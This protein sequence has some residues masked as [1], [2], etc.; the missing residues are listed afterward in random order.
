MLSGRTGPKPVPVRA[1]VKRHE[2]GQQL[3]F[4]LGS[5]REARDQ[6]SGQWL[7]GG[8]AAGIATRISPGS[9]L[10][11]LIEPSPIYDA[12]PNR[13]LSQHC[14]TQQPDHRAPFGG[15]VRGELPGRKLKGSPQRR[16]TV[17]RSPLQ[18]SV[19]AR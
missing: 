3:T 14:A 10:M 5:A 2:A 4:D 19:Y 16:E 8:L 13:T 7:S 18:L 17:K 12:S 9:K 11:K 15:I 6:R 1:H